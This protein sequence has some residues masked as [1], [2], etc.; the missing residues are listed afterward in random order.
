V[1]GEKDRAR[2]GRAGGRAAGRVGLHVARV[3]LT[4]R[5]MPVEGLVV[6]QTPAPGDRVHRDST[7][8]VQLWHPAAP[9]P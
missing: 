8:T 4:A 3:A 5:P 6:G 2:R 7:L 1:A 9:G